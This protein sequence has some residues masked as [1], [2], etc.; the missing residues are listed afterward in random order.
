MGV[1]HHTLA[2]EIMEDEAMVEC[3][4]EMRVILKN[5]SNPKLRFNSLK[6]KFL[7]Q[8]Y[9]GVAKIHIN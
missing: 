2:R 3:F 7:Y 4:M 1:S 8:R 9:W 6:K 5:N